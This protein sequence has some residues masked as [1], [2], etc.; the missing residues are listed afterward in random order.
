M[1]TPNHHISRGDRLDKHSGVACAGGIVSGEGSFSLLAVEKWDWVYIGRHGL[2]KLF[3]SA[4]D[5]CWRVL[6]RIAWGYWCSLIH[7]L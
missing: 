7:S 4:C 2:R 1:E 6:S 5:V 3:D